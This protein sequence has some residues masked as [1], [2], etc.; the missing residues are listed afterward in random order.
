MIQK[1]EFILLHYFSVAAFLLASWAIS[2]SILSRFLI[3]NCNYGKLEHT[4]LIALGMGINICVIQWMAILGH[5]NGKWIVVLIAIELLIGCLSGSTESPLTLSKIKNAWRKLSFNRKM[6]IAFIFLFTFPILLMPF[7][8][9]VDWDGVMYH[10][11]HAKEWVLSGNLDVHPW[12]RYPWFPY[13]FDLLFSAAIAVYDDILA[14]LLHAST[15]WIV[16]WLIF[17]FGTKYFEFWVACLATIIWFWLA[18]SQFDNATNDMGLTLFMFVVVISLY[19]WILNNHQTQWLWT[20]AFLMGVAIGTKY[21]SLIYL[22]IFIAVLVYW[23]CKPRQWFTVLLL[24]TIPCIYW[25]GRN[26]LLTGDP[27]NPLGG[28]LFGFTDWNL[29]DYKYQ[30]NDIAL[31]HKWPHWIL[32]AAPLALFNRKVKDLQCKKLT[33]IFITYSFIF[34]LATSHYP[35]YLMPVYPLIAIMAGCGWLWLLSALQFLIKTLLVNT[36]LKIISSSK[37]LVIFWSAILLLAASNALIKSYKYWGK[38]AANSSIK[39]EILQKNISGYAVL[40]FIKKMPEV[41]IYQFGLEDALYYA[42]SQTWGDHF[43]PGRYRDYAFLTPEVLARK[44]NE[45]G[46]EELLIH[47]ERWPDIASKPSFDC[48]FSLLKSESYVRLYRI[49]PQLEY[50]C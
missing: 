22:P 25:Y 48:Y 13:N 29:D 40:S 19:L 6:M 30:L 47:T 31:N 14:I 46:F 12:L 9:P 37:L 18:G 3:A 7:K 41:K 23:K 10:L 11:P 24:L 39:E 20:S 16:G 50:K 4:I 15:G 38:V 26:A 21:Q 1:F 27:F 43:G 49:K 33:L 5:L 2:F 35:R 17:H 36:N 34:W 44:L 45:Q 28:K 32:W 8:P 42:P